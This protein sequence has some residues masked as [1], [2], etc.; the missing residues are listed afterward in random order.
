[1]SELSTLGRTLIVLGA[2][3]VAVGL[4][5]LFA[6]K[7]PFLGRLPGDIVVRRGN[8][9]LYAPLATSLLVSVVLTILLRFF[10]KR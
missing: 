3:A 4:L 1:V 2:A 9:T 7:I 5:V 10:G 6:P 8:F